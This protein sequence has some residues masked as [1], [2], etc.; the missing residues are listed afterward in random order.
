M[1]NEIETMI[2]SPEMALRVPELTTELV[3]VLRRLPIGQLKEVINK[4]C[5][6]SAEE[7]A[8]RK[9]YTA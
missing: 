6:E 3:I 1:I 4:Y 5:V 9:K 2:E 8:I 7:A